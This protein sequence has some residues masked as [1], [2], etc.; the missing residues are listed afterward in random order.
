MPS[1]TLH[2]VVPIPLSDRLE[3]RTSQI[4]NTDIVLKQGEWIK[5]KA[6]S[7]S[8]KTTLV[9]ILYKLRNDYKGNVLYGNQS[10]QAI[11]AEALASIRQKSISIIFQDLRLF[12][13]LTAFENI[14]LK[15]ILGG[16]MYTEKEIML[17]V[18]QLQITHIIQHKAQTLSYG[19]QQRVAIIRALM[20][21]FEWLI[22]D[23]PFSHLDIN[24]ATLAA[25]L[26]TEECTKRNAGFI[27]TDLDNDT[28]FVYT[29]QLNL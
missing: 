2:Q 29:Q 12:P 10:I 11:P 16:V 18:E 1:I 27:L 4:W 21:P 25:Q 20:Q 6:S 23:E 26:I 28:H 24:N 17:M 8:G 13:Q 3:K 14:Q 7:G 15:N 5:I 19:E 9:H 22:M